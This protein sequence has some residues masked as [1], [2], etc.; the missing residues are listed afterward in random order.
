MKE[1]R[2]TSAVSTDKYLRKLGLKT[3]ELILL[4]W[5]FLLPRNISFE[6]S[7]FR[8]G[9]RKPGRGQERKLFIFHQVL[10]IFL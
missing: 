3:V 10:L 5:Y 2:I 9:Y 6:Q 7:L 4:P 1:F 8:E